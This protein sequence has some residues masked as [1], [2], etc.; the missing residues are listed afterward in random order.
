V[1]WLS[2]MRISTRLLAAFGAILLISMLLGALSINGLS[3]VAVHSREVTHG[4]MRSINHLSAMNT[5]ASHLRLAQ[6]SLMTADDGQETADAQRLVNEALAEFENQRTRYAKLAHGAQERAQWETFEQQWQ[7]YTAAANRAIAILQSNP[8]L[9]ENL[10][11]GQGRKL[12]QDAGTTLQHVIER[13]TAES[14]KAT[15]EADALYSRA[16]AVIISTIAVIVLFGLFIAY[17][18]GRAISQPLAATVEVFKRIS[19]GQLDNAI[20]DKRRDEIGVLLLNLRD[21]QDKLKNQL[22]G[23]RMAAAANAR[24][25]QALDVVSS[26]VMVTDANFDI[27]YTNSSVDEMLEGAEAALRKELHGTH[28]TQITVG[29]RTFALVITAIVT[30]NGERIGTVTEWTDRTQEVQVEKEM[31]DM[32]G[33]VVGGDLTTRIDLHGKAGFFEALSRGVNQLADN[34]TDM[35]SKVQLAASEVLRGA[36]EISQGNANLSQRTEQQSSSLEQTASSME[37]MTSTVKQNADNASQA[38][39]LAMAARDQAEKGGAVV[40]KAVGAMTE[41]N[42]AS[43]KIADIIVVIDEI[44]FQTN[45]LA[46]NAA[47]E[48]ARAGEQGRGFAVVA[49]EVRALAGR[50]ATAAKEIKALIQDSVQKVVD[51]SSLVTQSGQTLELIVGSVKKVSDIVAEIAAASREQSAGIEQVNKA[52]MQMDEMTQQNAAL[53]EQATAASQSMA[54]QSRELNDMMER[55]RLSKGSAPVRLERQSPARPF[56][57]KKPVKI[58][59]LP[60][61]ETRKVAGAGSAED[62]EEF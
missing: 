23:E 48:A 25:K 34:M 28:R 41:I 47:V 55:Y 50:S 32:I 52:V 30:E 53:V 29:S 33:A 4:W 6:L 51:G 62:W 16:R 15:A 5:A 46:L 19:A 21:M 59:P 38:N 49:S 54:E 9:A 58:V 31:Q 24:I 3:Q 35:V 14:E 45:L 39:Q 36:E 57:G 17:A 13:D 61:V 40:S 8:T 12:F 56:T 22:D 11:Q 1:H 10:L 43:T 18:T 26:K 27:V 7:Q 20:D 2:N 42:T 60:A 37:Q 44:A